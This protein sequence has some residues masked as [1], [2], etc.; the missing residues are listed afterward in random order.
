MQEKKVRN[1]PTMSIDRRSQNE[2]EETNRRNKTAM[3]IRIKNKWQMSK[4]K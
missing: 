1:T 4:S 2:N 3:T